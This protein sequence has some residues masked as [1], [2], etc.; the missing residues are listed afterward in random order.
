MLSIIRRMSLVFVLAALSIAQAE[1]PAETPAVP[2][3]AAVGSSGAEYFE[4]HVRPLIATRCQKCH[5]ADK[6]EMGLRLDRRETFFRGGDDGPVVVPGN[7]DKSL[8]IQA[9]RHSG[10]VK[11]P[12][13]ESLSDTEIA[14]LTDW[15]K[16]G[17]PWP[18]DNVL[19]SRARLMQIKR[20]NIGHFNRSINRRCRR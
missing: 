4:I 20:S 2:A 19:E 18:D 6:Q 12:P 9:V 14:T 10:E 3:A 5:G 16:S 1:E 15:V 13:N 11:M 7:P 17:A 8:L